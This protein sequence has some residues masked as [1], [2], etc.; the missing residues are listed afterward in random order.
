[1]N[2]KPPLLESVVRLQEYS[3]SEWMLRTNDARIYHVKFSKGELVVKRGNRWSGSEYLKI[4]FPEGKMSN[5]MSTENMLAHI[6]F[7]LNHEE[8]EVKTTE[9]RCG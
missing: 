7:R 2:N 5:Y 1:M 3:P 8:D 9:V 6:G 4:V